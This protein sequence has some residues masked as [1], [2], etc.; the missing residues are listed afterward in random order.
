MPIEEKMGTD[1]QKTTRS[2]LPRES[3]WRGSTNG[4]RFA[5]LAP[6][7][8]A[9]L[10]A[11][12]LLLPYWSLVLHAP[13][14]PEGLDAIVFTSR[15]EGDVNEIDELN[16]YIGMM[17]LGDAGRLERGIAPL[18]LSLLIVLGLA[19]AIL[20]PKWAIVLAVPIVVFPVAFVGDLYYWLNRA[21]HE[22]DPHAPLSSSIRPFT[23][24]LLG[25]GHVGQFATTA[26]FEAG[27]YLS[28]LA[29][30]LVLVAI[31]F[32]LRRKSA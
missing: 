16:H 11:I 15:L 24:H 1:E 5:R 7:L 26:Q 30:L 8:A 28:V 12:S 29:A 20:R 21:G 22:L 14:Y 27:F 4:E 3:V 17:K 2:A 19:A 18:A 10:L 25:V 9:A 31:V 23:P 32:R 13:Q 6:A